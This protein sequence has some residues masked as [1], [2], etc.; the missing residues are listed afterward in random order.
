MSALIFRKLICGA[1]W[2][3]LASGADAKLVFENPV[4][5]VTAQWS[6]TEA[7]AHYKFKNTGPET[8]T[9]MEVQPSCG[10]TTP[11]LNKSVY[12][13]GESGE[14]SLQFAFGG[15]TGPAREMASVIT[16]LPSQQSIDLTIQTTIPVVLEIDPQVVYWKIGE[17]RTP[18]TVDISLVPG[19]P[20]EKLEI[21]A[22]VEGFQA[23]LKELEHGVHYQLV[24]TPPASALPPVVP[25][26]PK[27]PVANVTTP[28]APNPLVQAVIADEA[29]QYAPKLKPEHPSSH[30]QAEILLVLHLTGDRTRSSTVFAYVFSSDAEQPDAK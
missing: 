16:D 19:L 17:A 20:F 9:I 13:P 1:A 3:A 10:C 14:V 24:V 12:A 25:V 2:L 21:G 11:T 8:V 28:A 5:T 7:V 18:K 4:Q 23:V 29:N 26:P 6:D 27:A 15:R 30:L 22:P